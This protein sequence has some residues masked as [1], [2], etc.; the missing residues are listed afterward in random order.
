MAL[1]NFRQGVVSCVQFWL[2][3]MPKTWPGWK[4]FRAKDFNAGILVSS[5]DSSVKAASVLMRSAAFCQ[6]VGA[7]A[8]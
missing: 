3:P 4:R 2:L 8:P 1:A 6:P 5:S 7:Q